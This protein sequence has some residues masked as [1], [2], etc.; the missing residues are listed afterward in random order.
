MSS[1]PLTVALLGASGR[2]GRLAVRDCL[3]RGYSVRCQT[4]DAEKL[5]GR[6]NDVSISVFDPRDAA[7][8]DRFVEYSDAVI[9]ALGIGS[10]GPT[11]LFSDVTKSVV[12]SMGR[13]GV[14]RLIAIT[15]VGAGETRGHGGFLYDRVIYPLFTR[16]R[17]R[18]K[19]RQEQIIAASNLD[20][21]IVR[22]AAFSDRA[23]VGQPEVHLKIES[24]VVLRR[25]T[26]AEVAKFVVEQVEDDR[27]LHAMPF[28]GHP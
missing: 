4:R 19:E 14:R 17:Y 12:G 18:D 26:P 7:E 21:I 1:K 9:M 10:T 2:V 6:K 25:I 5:S 28:I 20:W 3:K 22:P 23:A 24:N 16:N 13:H 27:Y 15:G 8:L 11:T